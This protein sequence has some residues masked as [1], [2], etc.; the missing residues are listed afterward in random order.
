MLG[1]LWTAI[2]WILGVMAIVLV[3]IGGAVLARRSLSPAYREKLNHPLGHTHGVVGALYAVLVAFVI[4]AQWE[5]SEDTVR[6]FNEE[7]AAFMGLAEYTYVIRDAI[8][9]KPQSIEGRYADTVTSA[10]TQY[11]NDVFFLELPRMLY[12]C[13]G[14]P[15]LDDEFGYILTS[16]RDVAPMVTSQVVIDHAFRLADET[17]L[18]RDIRFSD[19]QKSMPLRLWVLLIIGAALTISMTWFYGIDSGGLHLMIVALVSSIIALSFM[20]AISLEDPFKQFD[21]QREEFQKS[22]WQHIDWGADR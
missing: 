14:D 17:H 19:C 8:H 4:I 21:S 22:Y 10:V 9:A 6:N 7:R 5:R 11:A 16:L 15:A 3:G 20:L 18:R 1:D 2:E 13:G 12:T